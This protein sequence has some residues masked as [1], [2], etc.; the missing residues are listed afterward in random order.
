MAERIGFVG[1]G[2][3]GKPM[4]KNLV[5][6]GYAVTVYNR[7]SPAVDELVA[8]GASAGT[9]SADV[10]AKS[11]ITVLMVPDSPDSEAVVLGENGLLEGASAGDLIVDMSSIEPGVSQRIH[12]ACGEKGANFID[13][14]VSGGEPFAISGDL[15]IMVGGE[16]SD[17]ERAQPLFDVMGK[18]AVLCGASGAG[19]VTKLANQIVVGANIHALAEALVLATKAGVNPETVFDAIKGGLAGS[20]V[21]NAKG[22]MM[23]ERNFT[24]GFRIEL[25][26]KDIN[27]AAKTA[28]ELDL[29]LQVTANLQ[30][31]MKALVGWG[32]GGNDHSGI[33][34]Y[35]E[36]LSGVTVTNK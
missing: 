11:D 35:V 27:N 4:A 14:P 20:N 5:N 7:S 8:A 18:S 13:A 19:N 16:A 12:D 32:E 31:V 24:P 28:N 15:A 3:M 2:I 9:S 1:L 33:L 29:P 36:K 10:A 6:A 22:P 21:M 34:S 23:F 25:H 17:F 30:Q 26:Y